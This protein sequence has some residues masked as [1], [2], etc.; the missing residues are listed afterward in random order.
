MKKR[1]YA[2]T[3]VI[4]GYFDEEFQDATRQLF[5]EFKLG[6]KILV[7]SD[8]TLLEGFNCIIQ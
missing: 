5:D 4:G 3:S 6:I 2:D 7:L 1:I 8:L